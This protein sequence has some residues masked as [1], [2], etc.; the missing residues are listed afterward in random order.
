MAVCAILVE[1]LNVPVIVF[2]PLVCEAP[3]VKPL[4]VGTDHVYKVPKGTIPLVVLTGVTL[5]SIPL[6][7]LVLIAVITAVELT[8][9]VTVNVTPVQLPDNGVT[10]YVAVCAILS[11]LVNVPLTFS[12]PLAPEPPLNPAVTPGDDQLYVVPAGTIP[13]LTSVGVTVKADPLHVTVLIA[14]TVALGLRL[15]VTLN[16]EPKQLPVTGV[17]I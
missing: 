9:T 4:P 7:A 1:L 6:Q 8:V 5:N 10:I 15:T 2:T 14:V 11:E 17:I 12:W 13:L 3:P 16:T